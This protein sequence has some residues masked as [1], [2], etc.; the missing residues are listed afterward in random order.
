MSAY[1]HCV[2][3]RTEIP[4]LKAGKITAYIGNPGQR[5]QYNGFSVVE[6]VPGSRRTR[7]GG[8]G[9]WFHDGGSVKRFF[10]ALA[11]GLRDALGN[12]ERGVCL[13]LVV[14]GDMETT[15]VS[16]HLPDQVRAGLE[17][18]RAVAMADAAA[19][20]SDALGVRILTVRA[21]YARDGSSRPEPACCWLE[22]MSARLLLATAEAYASA[23]GR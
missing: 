12:Y 9:V 19:D 2:L 3:C 1:R 13:D 22:E 15:A 23:Y 7:W 10:G 17:R 14:G 6:S 18:D 8:V 20:M 21:W 4:G 11:K 5:W 16:V